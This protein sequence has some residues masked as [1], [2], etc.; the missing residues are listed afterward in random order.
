GVRAEAV[1][2]AKAEAAHVL[3][4]DALDNLGRELAAHLQRAESDRGRR[5]TVAPTEPTMAGTKTLPVAAPAAAFAHAAEPEP[6]AAHAV[7]A[8][9]GRDRR[10]WV[11]VLVHAAGAVAEE[12]DHAERHRL[13]PRPRRRDGA[14]RDGRG[15][16]VFALR[17][18][19]PERGEH[20]IVLEHEQRGP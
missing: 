7:G 10:G 14:R 9:P 16:K 5:C 6:A 1:L 15:V 3:P 12:P 19:D 17:P 20:L 4:D 2:V 11:V 13:L 8:A 18:L